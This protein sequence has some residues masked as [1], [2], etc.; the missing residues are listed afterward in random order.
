MGVDSRVREDVPPDKGSYSVG[1][2]E[3]Q[4]DVEWFHYLCASNKSK[5]G[6]AT[7][8]DDT[9]NSVVVADFLR[10]LVI[11]SNTGLS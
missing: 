4:Q 3:A 7:H 5:Q 11:N 9:N 1:H 10:R 2:N 6:E 8:T